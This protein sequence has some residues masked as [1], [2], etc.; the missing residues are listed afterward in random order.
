MEH[1]NM[2]LPVLDA[3]GFHDYKVADENTIHIFE[4]L[5]ESGNITMELSKQ[6][7]LLSV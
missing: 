4:R 6:G 1:L 2:A 5:N 3:L 7:M